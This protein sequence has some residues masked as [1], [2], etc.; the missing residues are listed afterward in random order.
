MATIRRG[1]PC[2]L[3]DG[4]PS[5][6]RGW[7][8][9]HYAVWK[10]Y[11]DPEYAVRRYEPQGDECSDPDCNKKPKRRGMCEKHAKRSDKYGETTDPRKRLFW[12]KVDKDGPIP[13]HRPDLGP[14]WVWTGFVHPKTGYGQYG[15][16]KGTRLAH[17]IAYEYLIGPIPKGLHVDHVCRN[18]ACVNAANGHLEPVT[19]R[20]NIERGDQGAFWGYVPDPLPEKTPVQAPLTCTE[21]GGGCG[22]PVYKRDICRTHYR[23]WLRDPAVDRP[24]KRTPEQR[25]WAK[26]DK[27][28]PVPAD[29]PEL[30]PCWLWAAFVN[31]S[32]GYG[33]FYPQHGVTVG[34]HCYSY[35]L[36]NG[37]VPEGLDVHHECHVRRCCNPAHLRALSRAE[38]MAQ[39]KVRR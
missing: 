37:P 3:R 8:S 30:G 26:V 10:K 6:A 21:D 38:N 31:R 12:S 4:K 14:C 13:E 22:K 24:S 18:R 1:D 11:G 19:P 28:G 5:V 7:C 9:K 15:A 2:I 27:D 23:R 25:F 34:A 35:E 29:K 36:A 32:T 33:Q 20:E 16:R 17:R 39:R